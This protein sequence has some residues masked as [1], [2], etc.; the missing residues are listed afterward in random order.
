MKRKVNSECIGMIGEV[1]VKVEQEPVQS[2]LKES[3]HYI[4]KQE[5]RHSLCD[6]CVRDRGCEHQLERCTRVDREE[7]K[8]VIA[9]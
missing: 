6:S 8:C 7:G 4:A 5:E 9:Q 1:I 2:V 3:P